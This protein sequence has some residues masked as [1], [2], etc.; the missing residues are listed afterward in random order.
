MIKI[1]NIKELEMIGTLMILTTAIGLMVGFAKVLSNP[2]LIGSMINNN[3][4]KT[5]NTQSN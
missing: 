3:T 2:S 4:I 5:F 1:A